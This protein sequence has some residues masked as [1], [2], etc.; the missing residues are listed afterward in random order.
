MKTARTTR[1]RKHL[2]RKASVSLAC[3]LTLAACRKPSMSEVVQDGIPV[4]D[5]TPVTG[6]ALS[7][8]LKATSNALAETNTQDTTSPRISIERIDSSLQAYEG[9]DTL[10]DTTTGSNECNG[11]PLQEVAL[12]NGLRLSGS[13]YNIYACE[14]TFS[15]NFHP[16][17]GLKPGMDSSEVLHLLG[18]PRQHT[19]N[20][21]RY[22]SD[23]PE[24]R[25]ADLFEARWTLELT[26]EKGKLKIVTFI[27]S[28]DDC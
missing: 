12:Q 11:E 15:G 26:F 20:A 10:R 7:E 16:I 23:P 27:P 2:A 1:R 13:L 19:A 21:F 3:L 17:M 28:M 8:V 22:I 4:A 14:W 25:E 9:G 18:H 6:H 24:D 5:T